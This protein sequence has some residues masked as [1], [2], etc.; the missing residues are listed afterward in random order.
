MQS[1]TELWNPEQL[2]IPRY[3]RRYV[4]PLNRNSIK[5]SSACINTRSSPKQFAPKIEC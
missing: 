1:E 4:I 2:S 3:E 5:Y